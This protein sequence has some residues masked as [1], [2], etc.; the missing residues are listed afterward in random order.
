[1]VD[2]DTVIVIDECHAFLDTCESELRVVLPTKS[3][4]RALRYLSR[5]KRST[6]E[7]VDG[8]LAAIAT[9]GMR[10]P[11]DLPHWRETM[12]VEA[13][14]ALDDDSRSLRRHVNSLDLLEATQKLRLLLHLLSK[15][16]H[17]ASYEF[18]EG[19]HHFW[20]HSACCVIE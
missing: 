1:M 20:T 10:H 6:A 9:S 12:L 8:V 2:K 14:K 7:Y 13:C 4:Q 5:S 3:A 18:S 17:D 16:L 11:P 19:S 15:G